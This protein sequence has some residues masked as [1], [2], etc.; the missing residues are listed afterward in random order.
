[1]AAAGTA[2]CAGYSLSGGAAAAFGVLRSP[3][4]RPRGDTGRID[5]AGRHLAGAVLLAASCLGAAGDAMIYYRRR[6]AMSDL[7]KAALYAMLIGSHRLVSGCP[8][9]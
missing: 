2:A 8:R 6:R 1:M 7:M 3:S 9:W 5:S 4:Q